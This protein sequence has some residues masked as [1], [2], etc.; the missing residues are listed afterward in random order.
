MYM[1]QCYSLKSS[2]P[3]SS[4]IKRHTVQ[5][6]GQNSHHQKIYKEINVEEAVEKRKPPIVWGKCKLVQPLCRA[7]WR[8]LKKLKIELP[9]DPSI[10]LLDM[11]LEKITAENI[12]ALQ[13]SLRH[14]LQQ[15]RHGSDLSVH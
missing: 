13:R 11:Y 7:V 1:F 14:Y 6:T 10:P 4:M 9:Y 8:L 2:H 5:I 3:P 15:P 12:H